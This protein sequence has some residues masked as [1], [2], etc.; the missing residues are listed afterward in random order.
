MYVPA[1]SGL[2][3]QVAEALPTMADLIKAIQATP[4]R[5]ACGEDCIPP[6]AIRA[7]PHEVARLIHPLM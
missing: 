7:V 1:D 5:K 4:R 6:D 3:G 2:G